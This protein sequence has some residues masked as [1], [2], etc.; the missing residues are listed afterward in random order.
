MN[1]LTKSS[2]N[3]FADLG[4]PDSKTL[5]AKAELVSKIADAI[6]GLHL[7]QG[8]AAGRIGLTQ[9]NVSE[10]LRG[11]FEGFSPGVAD[12]HSRGAGSGRQYHHGV[13]RAASSATRRALT[14]HIASWKSP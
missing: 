3:V 1:R 11:K 7:T 10:L 4:L 5:L 6:T 2:G 9:P 13:R 12:S 14:L 8:Q